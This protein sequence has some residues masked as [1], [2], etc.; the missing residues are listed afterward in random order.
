MKIRK[1]LAAAAAA[2]VAISTMAVTAFAEGS[3][4]TVM[5]VQDS[6]TW[7][8]TLSENVTI[9]GD[10]EYSY[11]IS[12]LDI[13]PDTLNVIYV[14]DASCIESTPKDYASGLLGADAEVVSLKIN[15]SDVT[16][17][18]GS[19][20]YDN[21]GNVLDFCLYN[22]WSADDTWIDVPVQ[23]ITSIDLT[24]KVT[25]GGAAAPADTG[26]TA[27]AD[28][29]AGDSDTASKTTGN[30]P[31]MAMVSVMALAGVAAVASKKRK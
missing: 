25:A 17:N 6:A 24:I 11:S 18:P 29:P 8:N 15:G 4:D 22:I 14:K 1:I 5:V 28:T 10:G 9:T 31:A 13:A 16:V 7:A 27:D 21:S 30:V 23:N 2:A 20:L 3:V 12:G 26:E 19:T